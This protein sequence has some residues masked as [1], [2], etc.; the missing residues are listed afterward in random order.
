MSYFAAGIIVAIPL[1]VGILCICNVVTT[2]ENT[3]MA[4]KMK[5]QPGNEQFI[6]R[7]IHKIHQFKALILNWCWHLMHRIYAAIHSSED[8]QLE[9]YFTSLS[10]QTKVP[11]NF[12]KSV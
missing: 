11:S 5:H 2:S 1:V 12:S 10:V 7:Q 3:S 8:Q 6:S 4:L 9:N